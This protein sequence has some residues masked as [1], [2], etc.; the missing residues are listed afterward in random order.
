[1]ADV[2]N[3]EWA[4]GRVGDVANGRSGLSG[5]SGPSGRSGGGFAL[6]MGQADRCTDY[7]VTDYLPPVCGRSGG[8]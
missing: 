4:N 8:R 1:M 6:G 2:G 7:C 5:Q 3:G